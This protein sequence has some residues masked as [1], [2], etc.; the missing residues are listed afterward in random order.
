[1]PPPPDGKSDMATPESPNSAIAPLPL[2][3]PLPNSATSSLSLLSSSQNPA[4]ALLGQK[5]MAVNELAKTFRL[6]RFAYLIATGIAFLF[7]MAIAIRLLVLVPRV[8]PIEWVCLFGSSGLVTLTINRM[9]QMWS[10]ALRLIASEPLDGSR[11]AR[12]EPPR[13]RNPRRGKGPDGGKL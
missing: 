5:V 1:M 9:L 8:E 10:Q 12:N 7:L 2:P 3:L 13:R 6:D 4:I 11:A